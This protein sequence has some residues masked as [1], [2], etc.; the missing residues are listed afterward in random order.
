[1]L[2]LSEF[3]IKKPRLCFW[4]PSLVCV[5]LILLVLIPT[6]VP[7]VS[8]LNP[9]HIDTDPENMLSSSEPVRVFHNDMKK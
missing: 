6:V 5:L 7:S 4:V 2:S 3:A 9:L 1:M 8:F